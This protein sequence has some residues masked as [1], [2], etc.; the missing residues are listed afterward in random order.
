VYFVAFSIPFTVSSMFGY[1][2]A[3]LVYKDSFLLFIN[4]IS[5][6]VFRLKTLRSRLGLV[7]ETKER[8]ISAATLFRCRLE[9]NKILL[10]FHSSHMLFKIAP[11]FYIVAGALIGTITMYLGCFIVE[12]FVL[13]LFITG[14]AVAIVL[15]LSCP[16]P[17]QNMYF[18]EQVRRLQIESEFFLNSIFSGPSTTFVT[19][20]RKC[21]TTIGTV[22]WRENTFQY[23]AR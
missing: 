11:A 3:A 6:Q 16:L 5:F 4:Y 21:W 10:D 17:F 22:F 15:A 20:R 12:D 23:E 8:R 2:F 1:L 9:Y 18:I 7:L 19:F 13:M 14:V